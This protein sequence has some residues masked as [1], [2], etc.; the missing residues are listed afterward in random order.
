MLSVNTTEIQLLATYLLGV[1]K[2]SFLCF[3]N[4][5][6]FGAILF[7][8]LSFLLFSFFL[9]IF[10]NVFLETFIYN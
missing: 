6:I 3:F 10:D 8:L 5:V 9:V 4:V 7:I 1:G 2:F